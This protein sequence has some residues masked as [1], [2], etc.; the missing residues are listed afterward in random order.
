MSDARGCFSPS[1]P[2]QTAPPM[3]DVF[4][5]KNATD[6]LNA[7]RSRSLQRTMRL[8]P[9]RGK[10]G[11]LLGF[12]KLDFG[13][14]ATKL[15]IRRGSSAVSFQ[16]SYSS[17]LVAPDLTL[18]TFWLR[19]MPTALMSI[20]L[21]PSCREPT[22]TPAVLKSLT[23]AGDVILIG[24]LVCCGGASAT[25]HPLRPGSVRPLTDRRSLA[26]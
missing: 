14:K 5:S 9:N 16:L 6:S 15:R 19:Q 4:H 1:R 10:D 13:R 20:G 7:S 3:V 26:C 25:R 21:K 23:Q 2:D 12:G 24:D 22:G 18:S 17:S 8:I 11:W